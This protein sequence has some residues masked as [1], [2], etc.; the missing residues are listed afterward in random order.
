MPAGPLRRPG[1]IYLDDLL[2]S[3]RFQVRRFTTA[4]DARGAVDLKCLFAS[5]TVR[6]RT[7]RG[8]DGQLSC[9]QI[10]RDNFPR[11][12]TTLIETEIVF[13]ENGVIVLGNVLGRSSEGRYRQAV[14]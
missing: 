3:D 11:L 6:G 14:V 9:L 5:Q 2:R 13:D 4:P 12:P 10:N 7:P 1:E 8:S